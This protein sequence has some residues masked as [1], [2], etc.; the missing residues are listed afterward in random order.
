MIYFFGIASPLYQ[1]QA[2]IMVTTTLAH[3][4]MS[5]SSLTSYAP[6][7]VKNANTL[8]NS[9]LSW[10]GFQYVN[11]ELPLTKWSGRGDFITA[12]GGLLSGFSQ[13]DVSLWHYFD[14][15]LSIHIN[16]N[17]GV[18][19]LTYTGYRPIWAYKVLQKVLQNGQDQLERLG[20]QERLARLK[21]SRYA[22]QVSEN[23]LSGANAR[24]S[25]FRKRHSVYDPQALY[26]NR[27]RLINSLMVKSAELQS[28]DAALSLAAPDNQSIAGYKS[29]ISFLHQKIV[30]LENHTQDITN[31]T[32]QF[33]VL[34]AKQSIDEKVLTL[35]KVGYQKALTEA[36]TPSYIMMMLS[37]P[38][39]THAPTGPDRVLSVLIVFIVTLLIWS[40]LR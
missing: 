2:Q 12:Y 16:K 19:T 30:R 40:F 13:S 36:A 10:S 17:D 22:L 27:M 4:D 25:S 15:N 6:D 24:L 35:A 9:V 1:S 8:K 7:R 28:Q 21:A 32:H 11:S 3:N 14:R 18:V 29:A 34:K 37:P 26:E 39:Q 20:K 23:D 38:S 5:Q 31:R 33:A